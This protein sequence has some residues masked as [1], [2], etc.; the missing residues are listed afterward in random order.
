MPQCGQPLRR[1]HRHGHLAGAQPGRRRGA[2]AFPPSLPACP[3]LLLPP[4]SAWASVSCCWGSDGT[5]MLCMR[6]AT[7]EHSNT[8]GPRAPLR[9]YCMTCVLQWDLLS[10]VRTCIHCCVAG[11]TWC[12][13]PPE[14]RQ[15]RQYFAA[16][17]TDC[18]LHHTDASVALTAWQSHARFLAHQDADGPP[19][20]VLRC[21]RGAWRRAARCTPSWRNCTSWRRRTS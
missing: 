5:Y 16:L 11:G 9:Y 13:M 19:A 2:Q 21:R 8:A 4:C 7:L 3:L 20:H 6:A 10:A 12:L 15:G 18:R 1:A 17:A 14:N